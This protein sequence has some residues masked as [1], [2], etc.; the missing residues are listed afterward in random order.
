MNA[1]EL[2]FLLGVELAHLRCNHP[3]LNVD[4]SLLGT[5]KSAYQVFGGFAGT[6]ETVVDLLTLIPGLDQVRK[7]QTVLKLSRGVFKARSAV[8]KGVALA[9]PVLGYFG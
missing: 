7:L 6:A 9:S 8:D 2:K 1:T 3:L 5:G 4:E